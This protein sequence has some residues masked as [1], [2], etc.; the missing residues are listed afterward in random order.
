MI[1][2]KEFKK[3]VPNYSVKYK[4][5]LFETISNT[6]G[7]SAES[8]SYLGKHFENNYEL[9]SYAFWIGIINDRRIE[10]SPGDKKVNFSHAIEN[11]GRKANS[12]R[13]NFDWIQNAIFILC[14]NRSDIDLIALDKGEIAIKSVVDKLILTLEEFT[15]GGLELLSVEFE[16][17]D[18][19]ISEGFFADFLFAEF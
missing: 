16:D 5:I 9:Y 14:F 18:G 13:Q 15:Y 8:K 10:F 2:L 11:W 7:G 4:E 12:R 17:K 6:G 1:L 19:A 3:R